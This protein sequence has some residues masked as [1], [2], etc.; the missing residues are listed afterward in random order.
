M[1]I[2]KQLGYKLQQFPNKDSPTHN[3]MLQARQSAELLI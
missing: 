2:I 1:R 3:F